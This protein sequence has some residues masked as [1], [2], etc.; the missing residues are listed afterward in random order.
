MTKVRLADMARPRMT[1][2]DSFEISARP[3]TSPSA[4]WSAAAS[5][6]PWKSAPISA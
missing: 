2:E 1:R 6:S 4:T 5:R 3:M